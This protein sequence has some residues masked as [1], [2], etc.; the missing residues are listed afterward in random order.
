MPIL[1]ELG[2][3]P[4]RLVLGRPV[5]SDRLGES[6]LPKHLALPI[7]ASDPLSSVA[8]ATQEI[9][10][11]LTLAGTAFLFLTP[12]LAVAVVVL[13]ITVVLS[14]RQVVRA[15]PSGGGDYEVAI[16]NHGQFAGLVVASALL[17]DYVLTVAVSV[18][19]GTDNIISA[20]PALNEYRVSIAVG[21][22]TL[23]SAMNLRGVR[24]SGRT[25]A[26]PAYLF[27]S[28]ILVLI[29]TGLLRHFFG[30]GITAESAQYTV[31]P[32]EG[33][34]EVTGLALVF[35]AL[36]AFASGCTALTGVEAIANGVPAFKPPKSRNAA[37]TLAL[38]G[39]LAATMFSGVTA[40]AI[41]AD[42]RYTEFPCDLEG[43]TACET[44]PQ[45]TVIAQIAAATFGG[46]TSP[47]FFYVQAAT[48]LVLI[49]AANTA[50]NGFPLLGSVLAQ[51]RFLPR[52]LH[53]RGDKLVY[54][55]GI[56]LLAGFAILLIV[57][58]DAD[59][60]RLIQLY[61]LGVFTA[62]SIGQWG[63]VRHWN[64]E[65]RT[66]TDP[67]ARA[68]IRRSQ[69]IN[70]VG[71]TLTTVVLVIIVIT[72]FSRGAWLV[73]VAM[74]ILFLLMRA[75]NRHYSHVAEQLVPDADSRLLPSKVHAIVLVSRVHKPT[76]RALAFARA[77]RPDH[78][79]ALTVNVDG[80]DTRALQQQWER[81]D[82]PVPLTVLESPYREVTRPVVDFVKSIRRDS[83]RELVVVFVPQYVVGHWWENVLHNQ[84]ALRLRARLQFQP[85]VMIT[86]VPWQLESS[87]G[88]EDAGLRATGPAPGDLRRGL[89]DEHDATP[90]G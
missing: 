90:Y 11:V 28:G 46:D 33:Y 53:T 57:A 35:F 83:P 50:F 71:G 22:V 79:T 88:R 73:L 9:L 64:R 7:F 32:E 30:D 61:I 18:S 23:L 82:I 19:A 29:V 84:S 58:F 43:F 86:S 80:A 5:R 4:K 59:V 26:V 3:L 27:I 89:A 1:S 2:Q 37:T 85:G 42:V 81:Y 76:L 41:L 6:L 87:I 40:L 24:E 47:G 74:P 31:I 65:L 34:E 8:Y 56:L 12:W 10:I 48:A 17:V 13:L 67:R 15:Y 49:L 75:I 25:F 72:K 55:N 78:L 70:T 21:L 69:A 68:R 36:R 44:E 20:F 62:F 52:Q 51:D 14:Y 66:E 54:S 77:T 45:R 16:K 39:G 60:T 63:M 38:M